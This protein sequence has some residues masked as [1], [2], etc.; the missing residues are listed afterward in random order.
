MLL[1][2]QPSPA[3]GEQESHESILGH[4]SIHPALCPVVPCPGV[5]VRCWP[6]GRGLR[7]TWGD[8]GDLEEA[9]HHCQGWKN[10]RDLP[11]LQ[12]DI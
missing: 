5:P 9:L 8:P 6:L 11:F 2:L 12:E 4:L 10:P 7:M 1:P 3:L